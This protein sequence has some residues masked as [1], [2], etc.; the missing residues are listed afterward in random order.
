MSVSKKHTQFVFFYC[1]VWWSQ[2]TRAKRQTIYSRSRYPYGITPQFNIVDCPSQFNSGFELNQLS[3]DICTPPRTWTLTKWVGTIYASHYT[4]DANNEIYH[5]IEDRERFELP[6]NRFAVYP[7]K[8][9]RHLSNLILSRGESICRLLLESCGL[10]TI[11]HTVTTRK[12]NLI[13]CR[14]GRVRTYDLSRIRRMLLPAELHSVN[15]W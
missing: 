10:L 1:G 3:Y 11:V 2:T 13:F 8:P 9:L 6:N 14:N 4:N 5:F 15:F 7:F 12:P